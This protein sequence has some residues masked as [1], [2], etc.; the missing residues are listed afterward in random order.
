MIPNFYGSMTFTYYRQVHINLFKIL[1]FENIIVGDHL[2]HS[3]TASSFRLF[4]MHCHLIIQSL[5]PLDHF[6]VCT[7]KTHHIIDPR[8][9]SEIS[10]MDNTIKLRLYCVSLHKILD[11]CSVPFS[12]LLNL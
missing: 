8:S 3:V 10:N 9:K 6:Y 5:V 1:F 11:M 4:C 12:M 2:H 7:S